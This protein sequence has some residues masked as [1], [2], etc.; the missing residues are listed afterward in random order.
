MKQFIIEKEEELKKVAEYLMSKMSSKKNL[1]LLSGDLGAGKT[2]LT[3]Y[4]AKVLNVKS[5]ITSP[6][7]TI[8]KEYKTTNKI[9][10][11]LYHFDVYRI[12][13]IDELDNIGF[14]EYLYKNNSICVI[15]WADKI[16]DILPIEKSIDVV[17][18]L[19]KDG[20]RNIKVKE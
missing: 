1:I 18:E 6:T 17:I 5:E 11:N 4:I 9:F 19:G 12:K 16:K 13:E 10:K 7:F 8:V 15:E 2:A 3:K 14:S 20:V